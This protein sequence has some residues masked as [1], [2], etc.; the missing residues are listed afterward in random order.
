MRR[1]W[2]T[3]VTG[4][5]VATLGSATIAAAILEHLSK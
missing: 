2:E 4:V 3:F 1:H 5:L